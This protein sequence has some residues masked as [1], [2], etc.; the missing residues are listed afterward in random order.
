MSHYNRVF[1][2]PKNSHPKHTDSNSNNI[3][4]N[5]TLVGGKIRNP[6]TGVYIK[7]DGRLAKKLRQQGFLEPE[8]VKLIDGYSPPKHKHPAANV[9]LPTV[10][11][12]STKF[13]VH[14][15]TR[16][17]FAA[18]DGDLNPEIRNMQTAHYKINFQKR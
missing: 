5:P 14:K 10:R 15:L 8:V 17:Q 2:K 3:I 9:N 16:N 11:S 12:H 13:I 6:I 4:I 1:T 7:P 18:E